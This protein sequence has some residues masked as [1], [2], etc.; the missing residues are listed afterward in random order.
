MR[1]ADFAFAWGLIVAAMCILPPHQTPVW[2]SATQTHGP[3]QVFAGYDWV[4]NFSDSSGN[5]PIDID[6]L[7]AQVIAVTALAVG[8]GWKFGQKPT[9]ESA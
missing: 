9:A 8:A 7:L 6:R 1:Q 2:N 3:N 4:Y 5:K